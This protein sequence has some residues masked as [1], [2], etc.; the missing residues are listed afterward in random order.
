[1]ADDGLEDDRFGASIDIANNIIVVGA[2]DKDA[3]GQD[4][5]IA[6]LFDATTGTQIVKLQSTDSAAGDTFGHR[7]AI[8]DQL[9]VV[10]APG[11]DLNIRYPSGS[12]Y[13]FDIKSGSQIAKLIPSDV[14]DDPM[15]GSFGAS[16]AISE[17]II[18][19]SNNHPAFVYLF[20]AT[21]GVEL[22]K[23]TPGNGALGINFESALAIDDHI[24]AIGS[25]HLQAEGITTGAVYLYDIDPDSPTFG[26]HISTLIADDG[27]RNDYFGYS[28]D[29]QNG[30]AAVGS[31][32]N[33]GN[34][35]ASGAVYLF[36]TETG[37]QT[38][39]LFPDDGQSQSHFGVSL[40]IDNNLIAIGSVFWSDFAGG[41]DGAGYI[42]DLTTHEQLAKI[43]LQIE[44]NNDRFTNSI[45]MDQGIVAAGASIGDGA[46]PISG[47]AYIFDINNALCPAD[48]T[49]D[50]T[51]DSADAFAFIKALSAQNPA[52]DLNN[53]QYWNYFDISAFLQSFLAGCP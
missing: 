13:V 37:Q 22:A 19:V 7:V 40:A 16:V 30:V 21:T 23:L 31:F 50:G 4:S 52:A 42:Y 1:M 10:T 27:R 44:S 36:D 8:N 45:T 25:P 18:A 53:D 46:N 51:L 20:D 12:L 47:A 24:L 6:Y 15:F 33:P 11:D 5:G 29:I 9:V 38:A 35:Y 28:V 17:S 43:E 48:F 34:G 32:N 14:S 2:P 3:N 26:E 49:A 41:H 39:K